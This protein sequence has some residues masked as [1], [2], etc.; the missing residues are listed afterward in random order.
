MVRML[1]V[2]KWNKKEGWNL[3][4]SAFQPV[5]KFLDQIILQDFKKENRI[6]P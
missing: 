1:K 4:Q 2:R 5:A 3:I 6:W